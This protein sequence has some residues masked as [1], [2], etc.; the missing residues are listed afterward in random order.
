MSSN[1]SSK[2][3]LQLDS[4]LLTWAG[5]LAGTG[6]VLW[7]AGMALGSTALLRAAQDWINSLEQPPSELAK[8]KWQQLLSAAGA[9]NEAWKRAKSAKAS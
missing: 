8:A 7:A 5:V 3:R 6:A 2:S 1:D 9:G 4:R